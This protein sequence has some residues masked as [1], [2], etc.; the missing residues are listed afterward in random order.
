MYGKNGPEY[1]FFDHK[2]KQTQKSKNYNS[3]T[4]R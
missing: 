1:D 3:K 2:C 4:V